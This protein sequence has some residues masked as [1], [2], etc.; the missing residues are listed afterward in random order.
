ML[1]LPRLTGALRAFGSVTSQD[2]IESPDSLNDLIQR[3]SLALERQKEKSLS[4][5]DLTSFFR[6]NAISVSNSDLNSTLKQLIATAKSIGM[7]ISVLVYMY[8]L[9][10]KYILEV[11]YQRQYDSSY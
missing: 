1:E 5:K 4:W 9:Y 3:K 10:I 8:S 2:E 11:V 7:Y 6:Q